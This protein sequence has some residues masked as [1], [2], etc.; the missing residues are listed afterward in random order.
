MWPGSAMHGYFGWQ[1]PRFEDF[2][3][4][5]WLEE[6]DTMAW[7]GNGNTLAEFTAVGDTTNYMDYKDVSKVLPVATKDYQPPVLSPVEVKWL[8]DMNGNETNRQIAKKQ[9]ELLDDENDHPVQ[10]TALEKNARAETK[11]AGSGELAGLSAKVDTGKT[12][13]SFLDT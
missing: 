7:L 1:H 8:A 9:R 2:E 4:T 10:N 11:I 12:I 13:S 5:S 3:Y 6:D